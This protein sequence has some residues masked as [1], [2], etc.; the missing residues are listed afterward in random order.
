MAELMRKII[1]LDIDGVLNSNEYFESLPKEKEK[2][3]EIDENKVL[4]LKEIVDK[5]GAEIV[6]SSTWRDLDCNDCKEAMEMYQYLLNTLKKHGLSILDKTPYI[7]CNRPKEIKEWL[8]HN[9]VQNFIS[10]D[11][12]FNE[13]QYQEQGLVNCLIKTSFWESNGG[14][15]REHVNKAIFILKEK[16][17]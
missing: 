11:D 12:D 4:L 6:L 7:N 2:F 10:L 9:K 8:N 3:I 5:T 13:E 16:K 17:G 15:Q 14:L 1:F